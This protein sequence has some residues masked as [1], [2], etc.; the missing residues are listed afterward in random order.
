MKITA[1]RIASAVLCCGVSNIAVA[2]EAAPAPQETAQM[3]QQ[4]GAGDIIVTAQRRS[5]SLLDVPLAISAL[6]GDTLETKGISNSASLATAVPNL[7]VSSSFGRTQP[8]FSLRGISVA[9]EFNANQA[10]P[11]GVYIDDVYIA[12][13]T[14]HGMGLF[15]LDRVEVLRGPQG[16]LFGRNT[17]GGAINFITRQPKLKGTEGYVEAGYGNFNT[18]KAQ[19][20]IETTMV[21]DQLGVR[22]AVNYEKGDGQIR[23]VYPGGPDANSVNTLQGRVALRAKPGDG[24]LDIKIR[25]YAGRDRG[26][27]ATPLGIPSERAASGLGFFEVNENRVGLSRTN[28]WGA[29]ANVSLELSP[30]VT[31]TSITSYD[32]GK[33]DLA[34]AADGS[35]QDVLDIHWKSKFRQFSEETRINYEGDSL[36]LV[37]GLFYGWDRTVTDNRFNIGSALG[38]GVDGG[39]FQHYRQDRRSYAVF[40][41][42]DYD[43]T[44]KLVL[45]L[46]ARYTWDRAKYRDGYAFLFAG[47][48]DDAMTP[49]AT[50]VPCDTAPGTCAYDPNARFNL[51][52][53]NNA[54]TGRAA[55]SYTFDNGMLV[56]ASY[57]RGYRSGAF[58]GGS[59]TSSAGVNYVEP[60]RVNAYEAGVKGRLLGNALTLSAAGFYYD[61]TNQQ[62]QDLRAGPVNILVNAPKAQV[63]GGEVEATLRAAPGFVINASAGYLHATYKDL[64]L[65]GVDLSGNALPFAPRWTAQFGF[66]WKVIDAGSDTVTFSPSVNYFSR[67]YF[68]PFNTTDVAGTGQVNSELQQ[69]GYAKV[70]AALVWNHDNVQI[71]TWINNAF[72]RK[73]LAYGLDLRGAGFNYNLL[74]P[75]AP[76]TYGVTA[77]LSF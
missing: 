73:V 24:A 36:K 3:P 31:L 33:L 43:L 28:A 59:Y 34:Q 27:Q 52:G 61:Y 70:D 45:T 50:T 51:D 42:G 37:G 69:G 58:N 66:D 9:N 35:P 76:R 65:Q 4:T 44:D 21:E 12:A 67:Q 32:G 23:N 30:T 5:Q 40:L 46:G 22:A 13:R 48:V 72:N 2:Q 17:T 7:Q 20:A 75:A 25:A 56:Y 16:T 55:L 53:K 38:A 26:T 62:V 19:G 11:V 29:A 1:G 60:E 18:F 47:G 6:G 49:I 64:T 68:S 10:S 63:Y 15:D 71:R 74:V 57:S 77:R 41:Q 14:S 54:L 8:N 39:F